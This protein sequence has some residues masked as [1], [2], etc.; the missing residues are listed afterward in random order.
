LFYFDKRTLE[1][2]LKKSNFLTVDIFYVQR[3]SLE[4]FMNWFVIRKPQ[5]MRPTFKTKGCYKWLEDYYKI[6]LCKKG[7]LDTL[8][9]IAV[10]K[11]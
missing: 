7:K 5:I 1:K 2:V 9:M 6:N 3:Y 11:I 4:N 8:I 10:P